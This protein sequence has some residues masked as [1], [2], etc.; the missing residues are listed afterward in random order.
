MH[1]LPQSTKAFW[2]ENGICYLVV[3]MGVDK[4]AKEVV[5]MVV[6]MKSTG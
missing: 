4:V 3:D 5:D 2:K 6:D 1:E